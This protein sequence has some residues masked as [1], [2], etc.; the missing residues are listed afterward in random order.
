MRYLFFGP[1]NLPVLPDRLN[2]HRFEILWSEEASGSAAKNRGYRSPIDGRKLEGLPCLKVSGKI[3]DHSSGAQL[4]RMT[5]L[6]VLNT[7]IPLERLEELQ[8]EL[9]TLGR[10]L[11]SAAA[12][13]LLP[14][15][16]ELAQTGL[17]AIGVR[18][19][20]GP[21]VVEFSSGAGGCSLPD[22]L[23]PGLDSEL[24]PL[25]YAKAPHQSALIQLELILRILDL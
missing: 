14:F 3:A 9:L 20:L 10:H 22:P 8:G 6:F 17:R 12:K 5:E 25:L 16:G 21:E 1:S 13:A 23:T 11:T 24:I 7:D 18:V 15:A 4:L 2:A 19:T